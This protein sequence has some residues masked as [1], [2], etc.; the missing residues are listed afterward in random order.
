MHKIGPRSR[1]VAEGRNVLSAKHLT[2]ASVQ[3]PGKMGRNPAMDAETRA[4][5]KRGLF[6]KSDIFSA[7]LAIIAFSCAGLL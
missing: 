2:Q 7:T 5:Q 1:A 6:A 3:L 4:A